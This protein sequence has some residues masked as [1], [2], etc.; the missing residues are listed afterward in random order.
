MHRLVAV[1]LV[2]TACST[3]V[4]GE[5]E[6]VSTVPDPQPVSTSTAPPPATTTTVGEDEVTT[7]TTLPELT[8]L[9]LSEVVQLESPI[10][11]VSADGRLYVASKEGRVWLLDG[12][13]QLVLDI[14][15]PVRNQG[16]QGLLGLAFPPD[17]P[18]DPRMFVHFSD[19]AGDTVI[20]SYE[21]TDD[22]TSVVEN[23]VTVLMT[24]PQPATNHN[25]GKIAF[26]PDGLLY[27]ALG[28]GGRSN[29][30]FGN[31]QNIR[32]LLG[33]ILRIDVS[34]TGGYVSPPDNPYRDSGEPELWAIGLRNPWRFAFDGD[35]LYIGDV[36]QN[37]FEEI[38]VV[39]VIASGYNFGWPITE[40]LHC[41]R[42]SSGCDATG[43]TLPL[44]EIAHGDAGTCSVTGGVVYRGAA[45][46]ELDG[47]YLYS[48][49][50]GGYLRSFRVEGGVA[51]DQTDWT[52]A[53]GVLGQVVAFGEDP[54]GEVLIMT[55]DGAV[56]RLVPERR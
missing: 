44:V 5:Q 36:G 2:L 42:P 24:V 15:G 38:N 56:R 48:D 34:Q 31:G 30:A 51:V 8:G 29:D 28:D 18:E 10:E 49:Y 22:G 13:P 35:A 50:C 53:T 52:D 47:H 17:H 37:A 32:S 40:G 20:A 26:G 19:Q 7:T 54:E 27:I 21:L 33:A 45:I 46:P 16:E 41:F 3:T 55:A 39:P 6:R 23:S 14:T 9:A 11:A 1:V 12:D 4:G 43:L 25:G